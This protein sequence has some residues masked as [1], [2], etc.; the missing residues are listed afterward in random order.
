[1]NAARGYFHKNISLFVC[2]YLSIYLSIY[3]DL[4]ILRIHI[5]IIQMKII[6]H[7]KTPNSNNS[8]MQ[9]VIHAVT[10]NKHMYILENGALLKYQK[11]K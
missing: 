9:Y 1:M 8:N 3:L 6:I 11:A 4:G 10:L 5:E 7:Q 2:I